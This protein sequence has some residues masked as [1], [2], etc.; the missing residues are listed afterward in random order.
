MSRVR[1]GWRREGWVSMGL[2]YLVG[3]SKASG[4]H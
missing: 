2:I 1:S 4:V 3:A